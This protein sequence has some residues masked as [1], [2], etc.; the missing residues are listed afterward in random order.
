VL[1]KQTDVNALV[2]QASELLRTTY[3]LA[4]VTQSGKSVGG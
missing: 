3:A 4:A 1:S 2:A